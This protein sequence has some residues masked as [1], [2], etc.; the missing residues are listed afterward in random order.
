[1]LNA[2]RHNWSRID[3]LASS[4]INSI[5]SSADATVA[6]EEIALN[7]RLSVRVSSLC[8]LVL[9]PWACGYLRRDNSLKKFV[10][11]V[12]IKAGSYL[13]H[14]IRLAIQ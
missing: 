12:D 13:G 8:R 4:H 5:S 1:M 2:P 14:R 7:K 9:R 11:T 6:S 3:K 10:A